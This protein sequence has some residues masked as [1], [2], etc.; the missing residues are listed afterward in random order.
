M[1]DRWDHDTI[2]QLPLLDSFIKESVRLNPLDK[3]RHC[4]GHY[5]MKC[6]MANAFVLS[7]NSGNPA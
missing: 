3:S 6:A 5:A 2:S 4:F 1:G 7:L